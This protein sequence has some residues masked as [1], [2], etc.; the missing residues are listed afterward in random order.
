MAE[1]NTRVSERARSRTTSSSARW[2]P[3]SPMW[4]ASCPSS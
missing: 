4:T 2:S 3:Y 1:T